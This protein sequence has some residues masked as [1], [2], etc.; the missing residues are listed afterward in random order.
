MFFGFFVCLQIKK[1]FFLKYM[2]QALVYFTSN[3]Q[4]LW[5]FFRTAPG[6]QEPFYWKA[7]GDW[8]FM[9]SLEIPFSKTDRYSIVKAQPPGLRLRCLWGNL[10]FHSSPSSSSWSCSLQ[11]FAW[12]CTLAWWLPSF[13]HSLTLFSWSVFSISHLYIKNFCFWVW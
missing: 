9:Y 4:K 5:F 3:S 10:T 13:P 1:H 2:F 11:D 7:G 12:H 8:E 6:L